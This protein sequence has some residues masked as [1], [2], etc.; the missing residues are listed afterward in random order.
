MLITGA[1]PLG[2]TNTSNFLIEYVDPVEARRGQMLVYTLR[3]PHAGAYA[4][5][6]EGDRWLPG[7]PYLGLCSPDTALRQQSVPTDARHEYFLTLLVGDFP[8]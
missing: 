7:S 2:P 5:L 6:P 1:Q 4:H 3:R 8:R